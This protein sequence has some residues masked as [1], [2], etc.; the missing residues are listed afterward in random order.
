MSVTIKYKGNTIASANTDT[1]KTIKT[2]GKYCETDIVVENVQDG[3]GA[4]P[5]INPLTITENGTYTAPSGV[6]GYSPVTVNVSGATD[7]TD[8][9]VSVA[10]SATNAYDARIGLYG[11]IPQDAKAAIFH[12]QGDL[13][14]AS[15]NQCL[16]A[17]FPKMYLGSEMSYIRWKNSSYE[18]QVNSTVAYDLVVNA[19][20]T[21][22]MV[23]IK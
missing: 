15:N 11:I 1:T 9:I 22:R 14:N 7:V 2:A 23:V 10:F 21:Y 4:D 3:G 17:T 13:S 18:V 19:G 20:D 8:S 5:V 16:F 12:F 6:D